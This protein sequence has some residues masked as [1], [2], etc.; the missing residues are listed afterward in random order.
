MVAAV[1]HVGTQT[2][3]D[4]ITQ[5]YGD[6][7]LNLKHRTDALG[8]PPAVKQPRYAGKKLVDVDKLHKKA[9]HKL[10]GDMKRKIHDDDDFAPMFK[11]S[12]LSMETIDA[13]DALMALMA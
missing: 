11:S 2:A 1:R 13:T 10:E 9:E 7:K 8:H 12:H 6:E 5:G 3:I 4:S